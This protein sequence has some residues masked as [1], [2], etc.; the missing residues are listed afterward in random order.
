MVLLPVPHHVNVFPDTGIYFR[1]NGCGP[2][3]KYQREHVEANEAR[4][5]YLAGLVSGHFNNQHMPEDKKIKVTGTGSS[6]LPLQISH[7]SEETAQQQ[8]RFHGNN[9]YPLERVSSSKVTPHT[10]SC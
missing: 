6:F 5:T 1:V 9:T 7:N 2:G 8:Q 3:L 4:L 10:R